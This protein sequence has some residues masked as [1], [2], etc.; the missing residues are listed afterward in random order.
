MAT[1]TVGAPSEVGASVEWL[2]NLLP[3]SLSFIQHVR[4]GSHVRQTQDGALVGDVGSRDLVHGPS[5]GVENGR[6]AVAPGLR[7]HGVYHGRPPIY[8]P[9]YCVRAAL[10]LETRQVKFWVVI[11]GGEEDAGGFVMQHISL[12]VQ[13]GMP[14]G[15][16]MVNVPERK[17]VLCRERRLGS[18]RKPWSRREEDG[19]VDDVV[20]LGGR[21]RIR[22]NGEER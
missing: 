15:A 9:L 7:N 4:V 12:A 10:G 3:I 8:Q 17:G 11:L 20:M 1:E 19:L 13:L 5:G 18:R 6:V 22:S 2:A 21:A 16:M 14:V